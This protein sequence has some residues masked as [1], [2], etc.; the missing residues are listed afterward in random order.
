MAPEGRQTTA[1]ALPAKLSNRKRGHFVPEGRQT[2]AKE[3]EEKSG[4]DGGGAQGGWQQRRGVSGLRSVCR[5]A[6]RRERDSIVGE[7]R[8]RIVIGSRD[9]ALAVAQTKQVQQYIEENCP[10]ISAEI[11][12]MKT[13]G[14]RIQEKRLEEIGG[15]GLFVK[16]LDQALLEG[17]TQLSVHS[18]KDMPMETAGELPIL[19]FSGREDPRDVLV[20]PVGRKTLD[21]TLPVGTSSLRRELQFKKLY[22][23]MRVEMIR[24][25][26]NSRLRKLDEGKYGALL[27]AAAGLKRL[28]LEHRISRYFSCGE[29]LPAAG[30]GILAVQGRA[31]VDYGFLS[32]FFDDRARNAATAERSFVRE[33]GG[34]C[35]SPA[36]AYAVCEGEELLLTGLYVWEDPPLNCRVEKIRGKR[37]DAEELGRRLAERMRGGA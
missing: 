15:K 19:G 29:M 6:T 10:D 31:G 22:P 13:T 28:G 2:A 32:G 4:Y 30:Q 3:S 35:S 23:G 37:A 9:S 33:L 25:N 16:E 14:D 11:L 20:L 17:R 27:L 18:L 1:E 26:L 21:P 5:T 8:R 12:T 36:A 24:G 7:G 34:G